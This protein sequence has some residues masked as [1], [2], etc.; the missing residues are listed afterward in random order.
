MGVES[1]LRQNIEG[2]AIQ[3]RLN[4]NK[5]YTTV[6]MYALIVL[7]LGTIMIKAIIRMDLFL[8][9]ID[10]VILVL[11]PF[12]IGGVLAYLLNFVMIFYERLIFK[13][14][15]NNKPSEKL[16]RVF[17]LL[18][19]YLTIGLFG[20]SFLYFLAPQITE[21]ITNFIEEF[22]DYIV[23][24]TD[25]IDH[26]LKRLN[27]APNHVAYIN[28]RISELIGNFVHLIQDIVPIIVKNI[29]VLASS[30][31][32]VVIGI[33]ISIYLLGGKERFLASTKKTVY[34]LFNEKGT[35]RIL[36]IG[37]RANRIFGRFLVGTI[38]DALIVSVS[39]FIAMIT[40]KIPY[41][42]LIAFIVG[43]SNVIPFFGPFIGAVPSA[44]IIFFVSPVKALWFILI[45]I[46]IQQID[47]NIIA[48]KILGEV[49][50]LSPFWVLFSTIVFG[51]LFGI[52][53]M[54]I[55]VPVF[56]LIYSIVKDI[57]EER[58]R[59]KELPVDTE[60]YI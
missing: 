17:S 51:N 52:I 57:L 3:M 23:Q 58:L 45:I 41:A 5:K 11:Q 60:K 39:V 53:G 14:R 29:V 46:V 8:A 31:W 33:I 49:I 2:G 24:L 6:A 54:V 20:F 56:A 47:G 1:F 36:E 50:G 7:G 18:F 16:I 4:W 12:I 34:S 32:N 40:F 42:I 37:T 10:H 35:N 44:I 28:E 43:I 30:V 9:R 21:G 59:K 27:L 15:K 13:I 48:P 19:T 38:I 55:G 25:F 22:P 26:W